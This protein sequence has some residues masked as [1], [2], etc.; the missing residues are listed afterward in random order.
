M[1]CP[2]TVVF[3]RLESLGEKPWN[4]PN[5]Q[6]ERLPN[7]RTPCREFEF[8]FYADVRLRLTQWAQY[9]VRKDDVA[10]ESR[11]LFVGGDRLPSRTQQGHG[12]IEILLAFFNRQEAY[13][14]VGRQVEREIGVDAAGFGQVVRVV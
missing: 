7:G 9:R 5:N 14:R 1:V 3:G 12:A 11:P 13:P 6:I 8:G 10:A 2:R 4:V